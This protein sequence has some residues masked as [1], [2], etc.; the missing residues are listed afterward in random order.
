VSLV[1]GVDGG[2]THIRAV[3]ADES[4]RELARAQA[5]GAVVGVEAPGTVAG[6]VA[7]AI[8]VAAERAGVELPVSAMW[9]GLAGAGAEAG[10]SA[11]ARALAA[12]RLAEVVVVG[13]DVEAAFHDAFG[14]GPGILLIAG[15]G[16]IAWGRDSS[17][18][19]MRVGGWGKRLGDEG[20]G[21]AIGM[22]ALR[23]A[24]RAFDGRG[25]PTSLA[26]DL[27]AHLSLEQADALIGWAAVASKSDVAAL[28]PL[29]SRAAAL[30][31]P[32]A[33]QLL[34]E[35]VQAL[36]DHLIAILE[37]T[38]PWAEPPALVLWGGLLR[39]GG[40]LQD[41]MAEAVVAHRVRLLSREVDPAMG[42]VRMAL[43]AHPGGPLGAQ[44]GAPRAAPGGD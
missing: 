25:P 30:G 19:V 17:G 1:I 33:T 32:V 37:R 15:T 21:F 11:V 8:R 10:R 2:G 26:G 20:S 40:T 16:S 6:A 41:A 5:A 13:T 7:S 22:G 3:I 23:A 36:S 24:S 9:A 44:Q 35:A 39:E 42:A 43:G 34:A 29:V 14:G 28:V 38:G 18:R 12:E 31:D 4:G 27:L